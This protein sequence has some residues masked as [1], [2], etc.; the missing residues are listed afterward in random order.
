MTFSISNLIE[1]LRKK[2][3]KR[4][5]IEEFRDRYDPRLSQYKLYNPY[6][7]RTVFLSIKFYKYLLVLLDSSD[8]WGQGTFNYFLKRDRKLFLTDTIVEY[9]MGLRESRSFPRSEALVPPR[10]DRVY[11]NLN[12]AGKR[13]QTEYSIS[14]SFEDSRIITDALDRGPDQSGR[15]GGML[16]WYFDSAEEQSMAHDKIEYYKSEILK[17]EDI[18]K[19][20]TIKKEAKIPGTSIILEKR[21]QILYSTKKLRESKR[22]EVEKILRRYDFEDQGYDTWDNYEGTEVILGDDSLYINTTGEE[23]EG[24]DVSFRDFLRNP[25]IYLSSYEY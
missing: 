24:E 22:S 5:E 11:Q 16:V 19:K 8:K 6:N 23:G 4:I 10:M 2:L 12:R 1:D 18:M 13:S 14:C 20:I 25:G 7:K 21:D 3:P 17:R 15:V 9:L